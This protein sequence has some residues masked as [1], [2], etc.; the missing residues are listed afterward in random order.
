ME[1]PGQTF[2]CKILNDHMLSLRGDL[3]QERE[4]NH[5]NFIEVSVQKQFSERSCKYIYVLGVSIW[6]C[7]YDFSIGVWNCFSTV[8]LFLHCGTLV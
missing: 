8:V 2:K 7:L 1:P 3:S 4:F 6:P 5:A